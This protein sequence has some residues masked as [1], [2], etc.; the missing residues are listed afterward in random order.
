MAT[1]VLKSWA[2]VAADR[3]EIIVTLQYTG[4]GKIDTLVRNAMKAIN[5]SAGVAVRRYSSVTFK[6]WSKTVWAHES[7]AAY[8]QVT[9]TYEAKK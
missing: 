2:T 7:G 3:D 8:N 6:E 9:C 1:R 4:E 5:Q